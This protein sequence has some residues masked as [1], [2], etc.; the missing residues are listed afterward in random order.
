[1]KKLLDF[2]WEKLDRKNTLVILISDHGELLGEDGKYL[3][4]DNI[5]NEFT[6][7]VPLA[8][9]GLDSKNKLKKFED[10]LVSSLSVY[11]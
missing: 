5:L 6:L 7:H 11:Y 2:I 1:M 8:V 10:K 9:A 3:H 4:P